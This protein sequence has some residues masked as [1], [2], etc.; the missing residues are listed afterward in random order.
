LL[1][2]LNER[3]ELKG[4]LRDAAMRGLATDSWKTQEQSALLLGKFDHKPAAQPL[5]GLIDHKRPEVRLAA[6]TALRWLAFP[7]RCPRCSSTRSRWRTGS[8]R[9]PTPRW[10][11]TSRRTT[12]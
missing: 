1:L 3:P 5:L 8:S 9:S 6:V 4:T 11:P 12:C 7:K 10:Q 2:D